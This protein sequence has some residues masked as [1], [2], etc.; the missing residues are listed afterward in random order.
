MD[1]YV[2]ECKT[3]TVQNNVKDIYNVVEGEEILS[4]IKEPNPIL[5]GHNMEIID[6]P[7]RLL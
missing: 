3:N 4:A 5:S 1:K 7:A 2:Y 6:F